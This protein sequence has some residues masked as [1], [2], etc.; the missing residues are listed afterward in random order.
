MYK[1]VET[2]RQFPT[3]QAIYAHNNFL[4]MTGELGLLGL[5]VFLWLLVNLFKE[6]TRI[7]L[8]LNDNY[9]K[10]VSISLM[11][12]IIAFL[13]NGLTETSMYYPRVTM[14]FWYLIGFTLALKNFIKPKNV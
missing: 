14:I 11:A 10:A 4:Q 6:N 12:C 2:E 5:L 7:Y 13:V 9:L 8:K 1:T 3:P